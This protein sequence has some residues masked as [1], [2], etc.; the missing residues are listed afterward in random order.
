[1]LWEMAVTHLAHSPHLADTVESWL[2]LTWKQ[3][4]ISF[5]TE[6]WFSKQCIQFGPF[7]VRIV[8][9]S[10]YRSSLPGRK[11]IAVYFLPLCH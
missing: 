9:R 11:G 3:S 4:K 5:T 1:M 6:E 7:S 2:L 10:F 8:Q